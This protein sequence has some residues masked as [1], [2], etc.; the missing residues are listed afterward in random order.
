M[1]NSETVHGCYPCSRLL[2]LEPRT[3]ERVVGSRDLLGSTRLR[4]SGAVG[5]ALVGLELQQ[6]QTVRLKDWLEV[7]RHGLLVSVAILHYRGCVAG[8]SDAVRMGEQQA[9]EGYSLQM[10]VL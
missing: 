5:L 1:K 2:H 7:P 8:K 10:A 9:Y 3:Q 6:Q 4:D